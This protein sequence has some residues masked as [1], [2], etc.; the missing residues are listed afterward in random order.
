MT[1]TPTSPLARLERAFA[2]SLRPPKRLSLSEWADE[3][4]YLSPESSAD[5][6]R[7]VT[8]PYQRG[9]MDA[10]TDP[11]VEH[12]TVMK[13]ARVGYALALDTPIPTLHGWSTMGS[14][15][16]G[17]TLFDD[18]GKPCEVQ[19]KS[20]VFNDHA[21]YRVT[22]CDGSSVVADAD[23]R[24]YVE[25]DSTFEYLLGE[26]GRGH[27][28]RP[29]PGETATRRGVVSTKHLVRMHKDHRGRNALAIPVAAPLELPERDLPMPPYTFGLWLGDGHKCSARLTGHVSDI[30]LA[31]YIREE[32]IEP[33]VVADHAAYPDNRSYLLDSKPGNKTRSPWTSVLREMG[34]LYNKHIPATYLR[35]S[36]DQRL[37]LLRGLLDSDGTNSGKD[38][39]FAEFSNTNPALALGVYELVV[40]LGMKASFSDREPVQAHHLHQ[41][42]VVFRPE[43]DCNPFRLARKAAQVLPAYRPGITKRRRIMSVEAVPP[44]P[45]QCIQVSSPS[46]LFLCGEAMIPTHNTKILN[47]AIA[48]HIHQDPAPLMCVQPTIEDAQGYSKEEI[49]PMLRDT[50]CLAGLVSEAKAKDGANTILQKQFPGGTLS[51]VGANSPRG[52]RR[53]SRRVV[54]FDEIDGYPQSAGTEGDQIKL[55]IRR[56]E[57]YWNRK[58]VSGSTPTV[59]DFSRV[60]RLYLGTDQRRYFV[61]CPH[62]NHYQYLRWPQM[63]WRDNDP[64]TAAYKCESCNQL[65]PEAKKRWMCE[66][67]EWRPTAPGTSPKHIGFHIWAAYSYSPNATWPQ[68]VEEFLDAKGNAEA[69]KTFVNTV[70]GETWEDE[71][72]SKI[73]ASALSERAAKE[74]YRHT[75][76]PVEAL[77]LT[78]GCDV[79]DDRLSLSVWG[80]GREEEGWLVDRIKLYGSPSRPEVWTQLDEILQKPYTSE[81][82]TPL[83]VLCCAIDSG[84][85]HT[86][87]VY[88]YCRDRTALNVIAIKGANTKGKPPLSKPNKVDVNSQGRTLKKGVQLFT[89]G[90]DGIKSLLFGRLKHNDPG[91][92]YLHF[93]PTVAPDYFEELTA[94]KQ[95]L[96]FRNGFP[97]RMWVKK[98]DAPNE[99]LDELNYAYAALHRLY[100]R[101]DR[102]TIW[103]QLERATTTPTEPPKP[104]AAPAKRP[105]FVTRW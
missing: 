11:S 98:S 77:A 37:A 8:L 19:F 24:W 4:A 20:E 82:G 68:L 29:K 12:V 13:S 72:A 50:A 36:A 97:E 39:T 95:I 47:H 3:Y 49:A 87:D 30:E 5:S 42:R 22:F 14:L 93:Y 94:E 76:P 105:S 101:Y 83:K 54:L 102:R 62:C 17:D 74:S 69:L 9:I 48:Y 27:V 71:Y 38:G 28:G 45:V 65:I 59:K 43:P 25:A 63:S 84:G 18:R 64:S 35:A 80:W 61:P 46:S 33:Y 55:G 2:T 26:R 41:Y 88:Q 31:D 32:G 23:H 91:A 81:A 96:R 60:E 52:F 51:L 75:V 103:D 6:G 34:V 58:I 92:G 67:G 57:Y 7:W 10:I 40:S 79:Q 21:C 66:R 89:V 86:N 85:H 1:A 78:V 44:V 16:V 104:A 73:G 99:A 56:T 90:V 53:V 70:L 100:Q 15:Q